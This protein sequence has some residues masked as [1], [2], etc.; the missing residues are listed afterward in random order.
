M[1]KHTHYF[2][3]HFVCSKKFFLV[4]LFLI[5]CSAMSFSQNSEKPEENHPKIKSQARYVP[6]YEAGQAGVTFG[7]GV[8]V[9]LFFQKFTGEYVQKT[10]ISAGGNV[11]FAADIFLWKALSVGIEI[12]G[13]FALSPNTRVLFMA[14]ITAHTRYVFQI[15]PIEIP[16]SLGLGMNISSLQDNLKLDFI[17]KPK[18]GATYRINQ[19]WSAGIF[20]SYWFIVQSYQATLGNK[21]S[22]LGNF[23]DIS[24]GCSYVF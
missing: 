7:L 17:L 19:N 18:F 9:P 10:N 2:R 16:I 20:M 5:S 8:L 11:W 24:I 1:N 23:L 22:R 15:Y 6:K 13:M 3:A 12:G 21:F 14:P 4:I